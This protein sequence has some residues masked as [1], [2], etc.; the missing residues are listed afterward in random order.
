MRVLTPM[1]R[2]VYARDVCA[3][4]GSNG[5]VVESYFESLA[6][7]IPWDPASPL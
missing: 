6:G 2:R 1:H 5:G 7:K 3:G 4:P